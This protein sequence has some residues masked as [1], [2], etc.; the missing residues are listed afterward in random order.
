M[1]GVQTCALPI[2]CIELWRVIKVGYKAVDPLNLTRREVVDCQLNVVALHILQQA[3][4]EKELPHIQQFS[5]AEETWHA[6]EE[7]FIGN[8]R[9]KRNRFEALSNEAKGFYM[10]DGENHEDMYRR[11]KTIA[12]NF[13]G[14]G[15]THVDNAW[16]KRKYVSAL[17]PFE[18]TDLKSIQGRQLSFH[19]FK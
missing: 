14:L 12:T 5:T 1:T 18:P 15:A 4:G 3:V 17:M 19:V 10:L 6:L 9:V 11:L 2:P 16:I 7:R 13:S 8:E